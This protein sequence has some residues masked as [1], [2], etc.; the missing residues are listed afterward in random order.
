MIFSAELRTRAGYAIFISGIILL[1]ITAGCGGAEVSG[2]IPANLKC[3]YRARP[4]GIDAE[5]PRLSWIIGSP[6]RGAVQTAYRILVSSAPEKL[7]SGDGDLW[8]SGK[9][10]SGDT[11][12][13][14]YGGK[15]LEPGARCHWKVCVWDAD[16]NMSGWS[17]DSWWEMGLLSNADWDGGWIGADSPIPWRDEG[18]YEDIPAPIFRK[19]L[20]VK[21]GIK[22]ARLYISGLG[23][24]EA[25]IN[26]EKVGDHVL[27]PGWTQYG[28]RVFYVTYDITDMLADGSNAFGVMLGNGWYNPLPIRLFGRWNLRQILTIGQPKLLA[29]VNVEYEDGSS[30][31][32]ATDTSWKVTGGPILRN[33]VYLGEKYDSRLEQP[34]WDTVEFDDNGWDNAISV[35]APPGTLQS[36]YIPPIRVTK[37]LKTVAVTEPAPDVYIFDMGQNFAGVARLRVTA[38]SGTNVRIRYGEML[39]D[40]GS[41]DF[42]STAACQIKKGGIKGGPGAPETAWQEDNYICKGGGEEV[43]ASKFGFNAFRYVEV[44]GY[45]GKPDMSAIEGLRMNSD[46]AKVS[47]FESSNDL[48]NRIQEMVEWTFL[49]NVFSVES[50]CPGREKFG[51]GGD[52]VTASEAYMYNYD[53]S[54]FYAK[55]A[56]DFGDD[57][58]PSGGLTECA[59][60][61]GINEQGMIP[62]TGSTGWTLAHPF[63]IEKMYRFY[64]NTALIEE[65]YDTAHRLV[66]FL[67]GHRPDHIIE[68]C[69]SDH[70]SVDPKPIALTATAFYYNHVTAFVE[71][72]KILGRDDD[73][74]VYGKLAEDIKA[75]FIAEFLAPGTGKFDSATQ[76][77]QIF[78]LYYDLV[79]EQEFD[80]AVEVLMSE[81]YDKHDGHVSTGIFSTKMLFDVTRLLDRCDTAYTVVNQT[82]YPGYGHMLEQGCTTLW[83][84]WPGRRGASFNHPMFGSVSEWFHRSLGGINP[85]PDAVGFDSIIIKPQI[86]GGLEWVNCSYNSVRGEIVSNWKLEGDTLTMNVTIPG[87]TSA[88]IFVTTGNAGN[89]D[90]VTESGVLAG[91]ADG[92]AFER[93]ENGYAV[94]AAGSGTY[95]FT[96]VVHK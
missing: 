77:A 93:M 95:S 21:G 27:D 61:I 22:R 51:Y 9:V 2:I 63:V 81:I 25:Y 64:G 53:M 13:I 44:T 88:K 35:P 11:I 67:H 18:F 91:N 76:A 43:F 75:A 16:D 14:G 72:A 94:F 85:A 41:L 69:I 7:S 83:E 47:T 74:A 87:N 15:T 49:S 38:P 29:Q 52:I 58:H 8:D 92:V 34:G 60:N 89:A 19:E 54:N 71:M 40:D 33:N 36:Q 10:L 32:F 90:N 12:H 56:R 46:L 65:Q 73:A 42:R 59:P 6:E 23:Y 80:D 3:E 96:S 82:T 30:A 20:D 86:A 57:A 70:V 66:D 48:F 39:N 45:P 17:A 28:K 79:P 55:V 50:D 5:S 78:A 31:R 4:L 68:K 24:Y 84:N 37:I 26:G 1:L 62:D